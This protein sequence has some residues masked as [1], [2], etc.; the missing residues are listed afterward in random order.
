[1]VIINVKEEHSYVL[2]MIFCF[3]ILRLL[4]F[5]TTMPSEDESHNKIKYMAFL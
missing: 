2:Q 5:I 1:M 4:D 3:V